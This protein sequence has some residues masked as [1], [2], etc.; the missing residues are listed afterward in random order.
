MLALIGAAITLIAAVGPHV[1]ANAPPEPPAAQSATTVSANAASG[2]TIIAA[3]GA[4][5]SARI[6]AKGIAARALAAN[7]FLHQEASSNSSSSSSTGTKTQTPALLLTSAANPNR[8]SQIAAGLFSAFAGTGVA[9]SLGDGGAAT[10][11][12]FSLKTDS[13]IERSGIAIAADGTI[14]IADTG[15]STIRRIASSATGTSTEP[16]IVRSVAGRFGPAQ[17]VSLVEPLGLAIDRLGNLYIADR[18]AS[19]VFELAAAT[20]ETPGTLSILAHVASPA[21]IAVTQDGGKVFVASDATGAIFSIDTA[22][23]NVSAV[24]KFSGRPDACMAA[25]AGSGASVTANAAVCPAALAVDPR[26]N[27]YVSDANGNQLLRV[28]AA[29]G[30][31]TTVATNF[32]TPGAIASDADGNLYVADQSRAAI[33]FA[34]ADGA[35]CVTGPSGALQICPASNDFGSVLQ[36]GTTST[37]PFVLTNTTGAELPNLTYSPALPS[38][39]PPVQPPTSPFIVQTTSCVTSIVANSSCTLNVTFS[40]SATGTTTGALSVSDANPNDTVSSSLTGSGTNY[41][42]QLATNQ[43]QSLTVLAGETAVYNFTLIPDANNPYTGTVTIVCPPSY[44]PNNP[45]STTNLPLLAYCVPPSSPVM[46]TAGQNTNFKVSIETTSRSGVT[47]T[48]NLLPAWLG[49]GGHGGPGGMRRAGYSAAL[50]LLLF[51]AAFIYLGRAFFA[52]HRVARAA[53]ALLA[54]AAMGAAFSACGGQKLVVDG[55]PAGTSTL[56]IQAT[57]QG[58]GR[59]FTVQLVVQ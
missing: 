18:G 47:S 52:H 48:A 59:S 37:V 27:L 7:A 11:A 19:A 55:T 24:A 23:R 34:P 31:V 44:N 45:T 57:A 49:P 35:Q 4:Q 51:L 21:N 39:N 42:L 54:I 58:T 25:S 22:S 43:G 32:K 29:D 20:S 6:V 28:A 12:Q 53:L 40:P 5:T 10:S 15:N 9:G 3:N 13:P 33:V 8:V 14:F 50:V 41:Q 16:G 2:V 1:S 36:G 56:L 46:L 38:P 26:G 30:Q 17:N